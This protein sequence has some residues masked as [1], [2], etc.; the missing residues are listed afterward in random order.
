MTQ[1]PPP[2]W[3]PAPPTAPFPPPPQP[4]PPRARPRYS[5]FTALVLSF[6]SPDLYRDVARNWRGIG[7]LYLLLV[8]VLT[9]IPVTAVWHHGLRKAMQ[10][11]ELNAVVDQ[12]PT[13]AIRKGVISIQEPEPYIVRD[14]KTKR[15]IFYVDTSE[16]TLNTPDA[17]QAA[18]VVGR[19]WVEVRQPNKTEKHDLSHVDSVN[20][21]KSVIHTWMNALPRW[22]PFVGFPAFL[23]GSM[24]WGLLRLLLYALIGLIFVSVFNA[25]LDFA[26]LMRLSAVAMTPGMVIDMVS[27]LVGF[28]PPMPFCGWG[29]IIG[30]I[31]VAYIALAVKANGEAPA[32]PG[33]YGQPYG[34]PAAPPTQYPQ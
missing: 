30:A 10:D 14:P 4:Q 24:V 33:Q 19:T 23:I 3:P 21:D 11:P 28:P 25:R 2:P 20:V 12:F 26:A 27:S 8:M 6:F 29:W 32:T 9:W 31:T 7:L 22:F 18:V 17:Q 1:A 5:R 34:F 16:A 13:L 15:A